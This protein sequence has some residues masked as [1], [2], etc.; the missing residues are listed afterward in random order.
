MRL[1]R[2][3][4]VSLPPRL[5][6]TRSLDSH[7]NSFHCGEIFLEHV[8][9]RRLGTGQ[10]KKRRKGH[11]RT[12]SLCGSFVGVV[13]GGL[14]NRQKKKLKLHRRSIIRAFLPQHMLFHRHVDEV[15]CKAHSQ[16]TVTRTMEHRRQSNK[17]ALRPSR[18]R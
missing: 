17:K 8:G 10:K 13:S 3:I 5:H 11:L 14:G 18:E 1:R 16:V 12:D 9:W 2:N 6:P 7:M 15:T 4:A